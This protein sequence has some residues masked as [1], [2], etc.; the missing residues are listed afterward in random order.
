[1]LYSG[2][3]F[4]INEHGLL[5]MDKEQG[6]LIA[7]ANT[8]FKEGDVFTLVECEDG[9]LYFKRTSCPNQMELD[10]D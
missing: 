6:E 2:Y 7:L 5:M 3:M 4:Q 10:F 9:R 8:P 1:M